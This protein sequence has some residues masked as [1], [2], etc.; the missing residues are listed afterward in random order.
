M[1]K[2]HIVKLTE[3]QINTIDYAIVQLQ[4]D[5]SKAFPNDTDV[6]RSLRNKYETISRIINE[7]LRGAN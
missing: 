2:K 3:E 5:I 6:R 1:A 4:N 7:P